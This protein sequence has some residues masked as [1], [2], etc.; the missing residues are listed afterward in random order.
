MTGY[1]AEV[2]NVFEHSFLP[3]DGC[4]NCEAAGKCRHRDLDSFFDSFKSADVIIFS[5]PVYN[6]S[7]PAPLK[8]LVDRFQVFYTTFYAS[9]KK[10]PIEKRRK[11]LL[12]A[13][14]GN[15]GEYSVGIMENQLVTSFS[16]L[17]IEYAGSVLCPHT[18]TAPDLNKAKEE[19]KKR[20]TD[21]LII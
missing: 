6:C 2:Y 7:F 18:D 15:D 1:E 11:A 5:S 9:G 10:Q 20:L 19:I 21:A 3:C 16:I 12:F 13:A 14:S 4:N 8:A 17:N